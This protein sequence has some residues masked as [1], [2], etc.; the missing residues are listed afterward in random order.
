MGRPETLVIALLLLSG[1]SAEAGAGMVLGAGGLTMALLGLGLALFGWW[2]QRQGDERLGRLEATVGQLQRRLEELGTRA[3]L[4]EQAAHSADAARA[5]QAGRDERQ[6]RAERPSAQSTQSTQSAR[7]ER[8]LVSAPRMEDATVEPAAWVAPQATEAD[9]VEEMPA[10]LDAGPSPRGWEE[11]GNEPNGPSEVAPSYAPEVASEPEP[12]RTRPDEDARKWLDSLRSRPHGEVA[13]A[14]GALYLQSRQ[15]G[16]QIRDPNAGA[17]FRQEIEQG[18]PQRLQRLAQ[19]RPNAHPSHVQEWVEVDLIPA[20]DALG[21]ILSSAAAEERD[22]HAPAAVLHEAIADALY[23]HLHAACLREGW[24]GIPTIRPYETD[25]DPRMHQAVGNRADPG[26]AN[27]V[28]EI[29]KMGLVDA[30]TSAVLANAH[31]VVGR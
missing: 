22:G 18:V 8:P 16:R 3:R 14:L 15:L 12:A 6:A 20:L 27:K 11:P 10:A 5:R 13:A 7:G 28:V 2:R 26:A 23:L 19:L 30:R 25:F 24:F 29:R 4:A 1:C 31:V 21:R 9:E 17:F